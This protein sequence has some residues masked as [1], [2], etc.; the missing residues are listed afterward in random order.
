MI[1]NDYEGVQVWNS[2]PRDGR[3]W[4]W[5]RIPIFELIMANVTST[6]TRV[7]VLYSHG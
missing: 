3:R 6:V 7:R 2:G 4:D 5:T 1:G